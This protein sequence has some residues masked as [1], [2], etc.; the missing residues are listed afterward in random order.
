MDDPRYEANGW[1][2][3]SGTVESACKTVVNTR[4]K[5]MGMRWS[6]AGSH[7]VCHGR[8][9]NRSEKGRWNAVWERNRAG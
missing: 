6:E 5:G 2:I 3:E 9:L 1:F 4:W 8:A 7:V